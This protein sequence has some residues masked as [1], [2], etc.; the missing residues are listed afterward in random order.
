MTVALGHSARPCAAR[1]RT[2]NKVMHVVAPTPGDAVRPRSTGV[3][4]MPELRL[5]G[6]PATGTAL[7][8]ARQKLTAWARAAGLPAE[9]VD[10]LALAAYEAMANVV[11]HA[12]DQPGGV[13]DLHACR[14]D[15][16]LVVTVTDH[17]Q[18]RPSRDGASLR[19]RGLLLIERIAA[20]F[21]LIPLAVG[22][23]VRMRWSVPDQ[24]GTS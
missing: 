9:Q 2:A 7:P 3:Q 10:D 23:L 13:F 14:Q 16:Q 15:D 17:G 11:D 21:E 5:T 4:P 20:E 19:G 8:T 22:T 6:V 18:F 24:A 12:Y 1:D